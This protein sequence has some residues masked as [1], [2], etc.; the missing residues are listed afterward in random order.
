MTAAMASGFSKLDLSKIPEN[1]KGLLKNP[2][3]ITNSD[4]VNKIMQQVPKQYTDFFKTVIGQAKGVLSNSIHDIFLFCMA[5]AFVGI[6]LA[7]FFENAPVQ[8]K[9]D[10]AEL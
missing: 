10:S 5:L 2:Q 9:T 6:V 7:F 3:I 4:A 8:R 1:V